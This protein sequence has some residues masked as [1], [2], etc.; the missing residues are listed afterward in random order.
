MNKYTKFIIIYIIYKIY[1]TQSNTR[2]EETNTPSLQDGQGQRDVL[3][4]LENLLPTTTEI[5]FQ[6]S[7]E[8]ELDFSILKKCHF[9]NITSLMFEPGRIT[10]LKNLPHT[11]V[12][13]H[14]AN[15]ELKTLTDLPENLVE[16]N[17]SSNSIQKLDLR[18]QLKL[19]VLEASYNE[20]VELNL[21]LNIESVIINHNKLRELDLDGLT[22]LKTLHCNGN[23][24]LSIQH[25]PNTIEDFLM[26]NNPVIY[27]DKNTEPLETS[28]KTDKQKPNPAL[29]DI[30]AE[31][32]IRKYYELKSQYETTVSNRK[33]NLY[34]KNKKK[35]RRNPPPLPEQKYPCVKCGRP[36]NSIF[37]KEETIYKVQCGD[38]QQP[39]GLDIEIN[40]GAYYPYPFVLEVFQSDIEEQKENIIKL[41]M[42]DLFHYIHEKTS[43][44]K[45]NKE[46]KK[47]ENTEEIYQENLAL[48]ENLYFDKKKQEI[49]K[50]KNKTVF[51]MQETMRKIIQDYKNDAISNESEKQE[52]MKDMMMFYHHELMPLY[53]NIQNMKYE[54]MEMNIDEKNEEKTLLCY[55]AVLSKM[56]CLLGDGS[57]VIKYTL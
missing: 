2:M 40:A 41:K 15:N 21:P 25:Y 53:K 45:F 4:T 46:F 50:E 8:G 16:L 1:Y 48:Y 29:P 54:V 10:Q 31:E 5:I 39:C 51:Q 30:S 14:I 26:E 11:I 32:A 42:D 24:L 27:I 19:L 55:P 20:L 13:L 23:P 33:R 37:S 34:E 18:Q 9:D 36:V 35:Y 6:K 47:Y 17:I 57:S 28:T 3:D 38:P 44:Q 52:K 12:K 43:V 22:R 7:L 49:I 56:Y